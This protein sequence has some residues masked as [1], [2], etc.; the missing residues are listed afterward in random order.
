M[1]DWRYK[2]IHRCS[3]CGATRNCVEGKCIGDGSLPPP[4]GYLE[5]CAACKE[6]DKKLYAAILRRIDHLNL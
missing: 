2:H 5:T 6:N 3:E 4:E 1:K